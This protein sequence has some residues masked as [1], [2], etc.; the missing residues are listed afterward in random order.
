[1]DSTGRSPSDENHA[2]EN[3]SRKS[4][5]GILLGILVC[6][7]LALISLSTSVYFSERGVSEQLARSEETLRQLKG[8]QA[9][10]E[11][12]KKQFREQAERDKDA[13]C[14]LLALCRSAEDIPSFQSDHVIASRIGKALMLYVPAGKPLCANIRET[15]L[16]L[17]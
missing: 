5:D 17:F 13:V 6:C 12:K 3:H 9:E 8:E 10:L 15:T 14:E 11:S 4:G 2:D 1:M 16:K 7:G